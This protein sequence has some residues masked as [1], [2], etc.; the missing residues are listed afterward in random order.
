MFQL[1][2]HNCFLTFSFDCH[3]RIEVDPES[4]SSVFEDVTGSPVLSHAMNS[5]ADFFAYTKTQSS[6]SHR[7]LRVTK[8]V[9]D[10]LDSP[11]SKS[12]ATHLSDSQVL[13][14]FET[15]KMLGSNT[16]PRLD[17]GHSFPSP[18]PSRVP[19][20]LVP[21]DSSASPEVVLRGRLEVGGGERP[22][23]EGYSQNLSIPRPLY[24]RENSSSSVSSCLSSSQNSHGGSD[25]NNQS[26][27]WVL[28]TPPAS[29]GTSP[30]PYFR[31]ASSSSTLIP[32]S[33]AARFNHSHTDEDEGIDKSMSHRNP[34]WERERWRQWE[35]I[36]SE[37]RNSEA[38]QETLV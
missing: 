11:V 33:S 24:L 17:L 3:I 16:H 10:C 38:E 32:I 12:R 1:I 34:E 29:R 26:G 28:P 21:Q 22:V 15:M 14:D 13:S 30:K 7:P 37:K 4:M 5:D 6:T 19:I 27:Q 23:S 36:A 9:E 18:L 2:S 20:L 8:S 25:G 35:M 31:S